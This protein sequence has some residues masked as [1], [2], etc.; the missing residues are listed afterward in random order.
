MGSVWE[1]LL[2]W[3]GLDKG[4]KLIETDIR[5][6]FRRG[7]ESLFRE[8]GL[9]YHDPIDRLTYYLLTG[10][11]ANETFLLTEEDDIAED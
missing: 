10:M 8:Y 9:N 7:W 11:R 2:E 3:K 1:I 6:G 5:K 4:P